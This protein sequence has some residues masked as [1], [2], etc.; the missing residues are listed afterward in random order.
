MTNNTVLKASYNMVYEHLTTALY[1]RFT[2]TY[3]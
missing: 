1:D 2:P 3:T